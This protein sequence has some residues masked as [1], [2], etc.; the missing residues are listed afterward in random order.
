MHWSLRTYFIII[1]LSLKHLSQMSVSGQGLISDFVQANSQNAAVGGSLAHF[2]QTQ[3]LAMKN[4]LLQ[5]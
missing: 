3:T 5:A 2:L 4:E 1:R